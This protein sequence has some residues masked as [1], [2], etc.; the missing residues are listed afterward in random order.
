MPNN[1]R[2]QNINLLI[3][4]QEN[5]NK[6]IKK[7]TNFKCLSWIIILILIAKMCHDFLE[8]PYV[9]QEY[10]YTLCGYLLSSYIPRYFTSFKCF[11]NIRQKK[12]ED[13]KYRPMHRNRNFYDAK[14]PFAYIS[15]RLF[16]FSFFGSL[17][18]IFFIFQ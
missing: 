16:M 14:I 5:V 3:I 13:L 9:L 7:F 1:I 15:T 6:S 4:T 11:C 2:M 17:L 18:F 12:K 8:T 10:I